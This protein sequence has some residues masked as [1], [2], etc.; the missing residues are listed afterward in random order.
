M[1]PISKIYTRKGD[2]GKTSNA[3]GEI[4]CKDSKIISVIGELDELNSLVG[5]VRTL[6][7]EQSLIFKDELQSIQQTIFDLG[8]ILTCL[9]VPDFPCDLKQE[10]TTFLEEKIDFYNQKLTPLKSF[11]LPGGSLINSYLHLCRSV[12]RRVERSYVALTKENS[13]VRNL[14]YLNRLSDYFFVLARYSMKGN[15]EYLW[16]QD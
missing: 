10:K 3:S 8:G 12:C 2:L 11:V 15:K 13:K 5:L 14:Q 16:V 4:I 6:A 1:I 9:Q 7:E